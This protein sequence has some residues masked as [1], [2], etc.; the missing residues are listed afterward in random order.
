MQGRKLGK[1]FTNVFNCK[2]FSQD[3]STATLKG[4]A[5]SAQ[6][7]SPPP[8]VLHTRLDIRP[9]HIKIGKPVKNEAK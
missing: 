9:R 2:Q 3:F 4:I 1:F 8:A 7:M 5:V 6:H